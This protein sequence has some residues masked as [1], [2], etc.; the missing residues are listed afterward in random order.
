ML[1]SPPGFKV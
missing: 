1:T